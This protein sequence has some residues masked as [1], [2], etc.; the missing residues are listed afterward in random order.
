[1]RLPFRGTTLCFTVSIILAQTCSFAFIVQRNSCAAWKSQNSLSS[2]LISRFFPFKNTAT[3]A[4]SS[5]LR[6]PVVF[7][8]GQSK[9]NKLI[10]CT[11]SHIKMTTAVS[12]SDAFDGGNGKLNRIEINNGQLTVYVNA[13]R[14]LHAT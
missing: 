13:E 11:T 10:K 3:A 12:I 8:V 2:S 1:M 4:T 14:S 5:T 7:A 6:T 9:S